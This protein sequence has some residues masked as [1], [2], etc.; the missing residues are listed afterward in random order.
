MFIRDNIAE[1]DRIAKTHLKGYNYKKTHNWYEN[2]QNE[3]L[4]KEFYAYHS[5]QSEW[6]ADEE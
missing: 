1:A 4:F 2:Y 6:D 5:S 3:E